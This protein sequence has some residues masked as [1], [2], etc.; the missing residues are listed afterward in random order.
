M[1]LGRTNTAMLYFVG[2]LLGGSLMGISMYL[3]SIAYDDPRYAVAF[4][5]GIFLYSLF[6][7]LSGAPFLLFGTYV[8]LRIAR[9]L[10]A[11]SPFLWAAIG[12]ALGPLLLFACSAVFF[13][14]RGEPPRAGYSAPINLHSLLENNRWWPTIPAGAAAAFVLCFVDRYLAT[15]NRI[16]TTV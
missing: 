3:D 13:G 1:T 5:P 11:T 6:A 8:L 4:V 15:K 16:Q 10:G 9:S 2:W 12:A 14:L 7:L